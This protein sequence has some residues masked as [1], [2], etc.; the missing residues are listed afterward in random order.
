MAM[1]LEHCEDR[2]PKSCTLFPFNRV[3]NP[4]EVTTEQFGQIL[5]NQFWIFS[6]RY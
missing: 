3:G 5:E 4:L 1:F 6:S 2:C